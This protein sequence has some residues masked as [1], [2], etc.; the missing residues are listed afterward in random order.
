MKFLISIFLF[1]YIL[2]LLLSS[3]GSYVF[4]YNQGAEEQYQLD[5]F[6]P[7]ETLYEMCENN[8]FINNQ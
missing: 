5:R 2:V 4:G 3:Y 7:S 6:I 8:G 1:F